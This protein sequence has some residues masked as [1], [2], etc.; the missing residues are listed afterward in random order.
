MI[1]RYL[2]NASTINKIRIFAQVSYDGVERVHSS[3]FNKFLL[4]GDSG[5]EDVNGAIV[6]HPFIVGRKTDQQV[7]RVSD[8]DLCHLGNES[9][10]SSSTPAIGCDDLPIDDASGPG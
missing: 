3:G 1:S 6:V 10:H 4:N 2:I 7:A 8:A 9:V 5:T